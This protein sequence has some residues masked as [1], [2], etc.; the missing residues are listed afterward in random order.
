MTFEQRPK[1]S[2]PMIWSCKNILMVMQEYISELDSNMLTNRAKFSWC[3]T[4]LML[5]G[6]IFPYDVVS[7]QLL[8]LSTA[9]VFMHCPTPGGCG[10]HHQH[11]HCNCYQRF[12]MWRTNVALRPNN[13]L[14]L[15]MLI[16]LL[17]MLITRKTSTLR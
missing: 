16:S 9:C 4:L 5:F 13:S 12:G 15:L 11:P 3:L 7:G 1:R 14:K 17:P 6:S 8:L 2:I 10:G